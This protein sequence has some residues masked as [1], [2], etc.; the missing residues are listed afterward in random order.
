MLFDKLFGKSA[1]KKYEKAFGK[2]SKPAIHL[3]DDWNREFS[4]FGSTPIVPK[5]LEWPEYN[6]RS[7][8]FLMQL[9][10]SDINKDGYLPDLP[11][12][13]LLYVF[14]DDEQPWGREPEDRG[15]WRILFFEETSE[16]KMRRYPKDLKTRYKEKY[17]CAKNITTYQ[18]MEDDRILDA[19]ESDDNDDEYYDF[20]D[21]VYGDEPLHHLGGYCDPIQGA[22]MDLD[23]QLVSNGISVDSETEHMK[24]RGKIL[25]EG[26]DEWTLLLQ[27][28]SDDYTEMMWGDS[29]MLYF[30]IRKTDLA[31][32]NFDN[33]WMFLQCY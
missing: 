23:C 26:R 33:V 22:D 6:G 24:E 30:W 11:T 7:L 28:D 17:I 31:A 25:A 1:W 16:L 10:F 4:K 8:A 14:Y 20:R 27:I 32:H 12:S 15:A 2:Y 18:P 3:V 9:R 29:G 21:S 13:G 5:E 19:L